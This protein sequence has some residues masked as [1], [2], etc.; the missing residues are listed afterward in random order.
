MSSPKCSSQRVH[1]A[2]KI[3]SSLRGNTRITIRIKWNPYADN[4]F[5][6]R[7]NNN[8]A[9]LNYQLEQTASNSARN[10]QWQSMWS[11]V[12]GDK[13]S[14]YCNPEVVESS[15]HS[16]E[17]RHMYVLRESS[18]LWFVWSSSGIP[19]T[20]VLNF[21]PNQRVKFLDASTRT[22]SGRTKSWK[23]LFHPNKTMIVD[24]T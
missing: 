21:W 5:L 9:R 11:D 1:W 19:K 18:N 2:E 23:H 13:S 20:Q 4:R 24:H 3:R 12:K 22:G 7:E 16:T 14:C 8:W 17:R 6:Y 15:M 10:I